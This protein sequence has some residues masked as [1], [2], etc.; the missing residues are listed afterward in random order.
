[1]IIPGM[2]LRY[3]IPAAR[4]RA[5][6]VV[7]RSRFVASAAPTASVAE[8]R[9]FIDAIRAE[10]PDAGHH[11]YAF[12][13]GHG[14]SVIHGMSDDG[15]PAGTAGRPT[16]AVVAGSGLG[17]LCLV[18]SRY[19]GGVKLGTGG[20]VKAYTEAAQ[21][22][23]E[24]LPRGIHETTEQVAI[25]LSYAQYDTVKR[26]CE[27]HAAEIEDEAFGAAVTLRAR[28]AVDRIAALA[29]DLA[30]ASAGSVDLRRIE[31]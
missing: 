12:A 17:D 8:A 2:S 14:S 5:E 13:I 15:E 30:E 26:L 22:L 28:L 6:I 20:L 25:H 24:G 3:P 16:L 19:F 11:V 21:A 18:T 27:A 9:A 4:H 23:L 29:A 1:M 7:R 10:L 31:R